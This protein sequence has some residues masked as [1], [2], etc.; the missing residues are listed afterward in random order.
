MDGPSLLFFFCPFP[1]VPNS[2]LRFLLFTLMFCCNSQLVP[3]THE[4]KKWFYCK[5]L[6]VQTGLG[7]FTEL[8][9]KET[10]ICT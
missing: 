5:A 1:S 4:D 7:K 9:S 3:T 10:M 6:G 8:N 2:L